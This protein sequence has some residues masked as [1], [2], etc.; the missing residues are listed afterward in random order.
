MFKLQGKTC[1]QKS[2]IQVT[3]KKKPVHISLYLNKPSNFSPE[4]VQYSKDRSDSFNPVSFAS[5]NSSPKTNSVLLASHHLSQT[6]TPYKSPNRKYS[7]LHYE[8]DPPVLNIRKVTGHLSID[9]SQESRYALMRQRKGVSA[10]NNAKSVKKIQ[11]TVKRITL[12]DL[13][14]NLPMII[15]SKRYKRKIRYRPSITDSFN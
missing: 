12:K 10:G 7:Y 4:P 14:I 8:F 11:E 13:Q 9:H 2:S 6:P 5:N 15:K 1:T 3:I